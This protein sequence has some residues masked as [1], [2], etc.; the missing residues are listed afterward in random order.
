MI[1]FTPFGSVMLASAIFTGVVMMAAKHL[2]FSIQNI[3]MI[4][5]S[6]VLIALEVKRSKALR[7]IKQEE[8]NTYKKTA[9]TILGI[10]L[11]L[12]VATVGFVHATMGKMG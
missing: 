2:D 9:Y 10:E 6:L 1:I 12:L 11:V 7:Y 3:V 4:V 5:V 8:L